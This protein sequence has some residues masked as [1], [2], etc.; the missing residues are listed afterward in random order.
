[1]SEVLFPHYPSIMN[2]S[3]DKYREEIK[4]IATYVGGKLYST[5]KSGVEQYI[6]A[7]TYSKLHNNF[8]SIIFTLY[9]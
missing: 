1:M 7:C 6:H 9:Y 4:K 5:R 2:H 3:T 8:S